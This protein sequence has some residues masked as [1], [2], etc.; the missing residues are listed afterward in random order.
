MS[1]Y[2]VQMKGIE[3]SYEKMKYSMAWI[4]CSKREVFMHFWARM[5]QVKRP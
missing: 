1:D 4:S 5:V 3:K 2:V